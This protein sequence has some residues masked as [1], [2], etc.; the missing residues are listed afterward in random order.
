MLRVFTVLYFPEEDL[1]SPA[2]SKLSPTPSIGVIISFPLKGIETLS[3]SH[4]KNVPPLHAV[5]NM[6]ILSCFFPITAMIL[7]RS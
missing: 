2:V 6:Y 3:P 1:S 4:K 5:W 7:V